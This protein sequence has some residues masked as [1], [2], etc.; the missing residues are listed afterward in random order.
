E[1][2]NART[3]ISFATFE[4][5]NPSGVM[6][7]TATPDT[8]RVPSN[9]L[10]SV[11]AAELKT[12]QMIKLPVLL[13]AEP[14]WQQCL[15]DAIAR[16]DEL[17]KLADDE[18]RAG[19]PYLRPLVLIQSEP[20]RQGMETLDAKRVKQELVENHRIPVD[21]IVIATGEERG[22]EEIDRRY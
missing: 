22:L 20:R 8:E 7:L 16:R 11:G 12:A 17:Q 19:A 4:R 1:A 3:E 6:E 10:H 13:E 18:H 9:V 2:H 15:G 21:E 14:D 5:F